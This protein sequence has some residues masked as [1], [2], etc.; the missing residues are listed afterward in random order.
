MGPVAFTENLAVD[1]V[2]TDTL[3]AVSYTHL[4]VYKRQQLIIATHSPILLAYPRARI[5]QCSESGLAEIRYTDTEHHQ[6][7]KDFLNAHEQRLER[8]LGEEERGLEA[9]RR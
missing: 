6:I 7:T 5:Y 1:L 8:L 9:S 2:L 3:K 4:D